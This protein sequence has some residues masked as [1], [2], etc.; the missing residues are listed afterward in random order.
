MKPLGSDDV[1]E[2]QITKR[3]PGKILLQIKITELF[4]G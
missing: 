4:F 3:E 1:Y 2:P